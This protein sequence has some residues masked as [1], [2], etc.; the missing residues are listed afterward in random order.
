MFEILPSK[1]IKGKGDKTV[2]SKEGGKTKQRATVMVL[3]D[4]HGNKYPP[5]V[6]VKAPMSKIKKKKAEN[7]KTQNGF[8]DII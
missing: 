7:E 8:W 1:T 2:W 4:M 5:F 3:G 6:I